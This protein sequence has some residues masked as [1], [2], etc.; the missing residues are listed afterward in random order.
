MF[1]LINDNELILGPIQFNHRLINSALEEDLEVDYRVSSS[2]YS[3]VPIIFDE[4]IKI[5]KV[6]DSK[7]DYNS[8]Y[9]SLTLHKYEVLDN[10]V[11]FYYEKN[12]IDLNII[13]NEYK[14]IISNDRWKKENYGHIIFTLNDDEIKISTSR[15][16]RIS[17]LNKLATGSNSYK[18][19]FNSGWFDITGENL[20]QILTKID[21]KVQKDFDWEFE[22]IEEINSCTSIDELNQIE[23]FNDEAKIL[24]NT[25]SFL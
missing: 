5:L 10:E 15:E 19:K 22:K 17:L 24:N 16:N 12:Q 23:Y 25:A 18:F 11:I 8:R 1:A 9:E 4:K 6:I 3:N 21:E 14:N 13:K 2:D 7:P 20:R